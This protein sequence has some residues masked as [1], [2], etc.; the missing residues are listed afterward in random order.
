[1][2]HRLQT[3]CKSGHEFTPENTYLRRHKSGAVHRRCRACVL[4]SNKTWDVFKRTEGVH[5]SKKSILR[6]AGVHRDP[7]TGRRT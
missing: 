7:A 3:H 6:R 2:G 4:E 1:M 5:A